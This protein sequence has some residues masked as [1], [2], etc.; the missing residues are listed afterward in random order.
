[1]EQIE[2]LLRAR[3]PDVEQPPLLL[4]LRR[5]VVGAGERE[6]AVLEAGDEHH[7]ELEPLGVVHRHE[8]DRVG[9]G[10]ERVDAGDE[11]RALE[12][13]VERA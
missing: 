7:G 1:V 12:E 6:E 3:D 13:V 5:V 10:V 8:R 9:V 2:L 4:E 11:R